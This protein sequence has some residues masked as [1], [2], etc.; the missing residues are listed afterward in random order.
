MIRLQ[1]RVFAPPEGVDPELTAVPLRA[2]RRHVFVQFNEIPSLQERR[3]IESDQLRILDPLPERAFFASVPNKLDVFKKLAS[4]SVRWIGAIHD[5]D[6]ILPELLKNGPPKY[7]ARGSGTSAYIVEFFADVD[8]AAQRRVLVQHHADQG[9]GRLIPINGWNIVMADAEL[10]PL[11]HED[12]VKWIVPAPEPPTVDND[13]VRS[14]TGVNS[15]P[16][17]SAPYNLSGSGVTIG[18]W[19]PARAFFPHPDLSGHAVAASTAVG[20]SERPTMHAENV[21]VNGAFDIGENI[22]SDM[23]DS[24]TVT[25]GDLRGSAVGAFAIG[26]VVAGADA[27]V[28]TALINFVGNTRSFDANFNGGYDPGEPFYLDANANH[29]VDVGETRLTA[30]GAFVAGSIVAVG[31]ADIGRVITRPTGS[32]IDSHPTHVACTAVGTGLQSVASGGS[33]NQWKGVAPS[34]SLRG[35][36]ASGLNAGYVDAATNAVAI[37]TNSWGSTHCFQTS[38]DNCYD[39]TSEFYDSVISGRQSSGVAS[40]LARRISIFG[41]AGNAGYPERHNESVAVN[42][43]FDNGEAVYTDFD[44]SGTV[45]LGDRRITASGAFAAG[46]FVAAGNADIGAALANFNGNERHPNSGGFIAGGAVYRDLDNSGTVTVGDLRITGAGAFAAGST[47]AVGNADIGTGLRMFAMWGTVRVPNSAKGTVEVANIASDNNV[48]DVASSRGPTSDGRLKPDISGPGI[49]FSG[50]LG[51]TSC[52]PPNSYFVDVGTS[53]AT[54]AVAGAGALVSEWYATA[55]VAAGPTPDALRALLVHSA[56]DK[57]AI[58]AVPGVFTGPDFQYGYG[59]AR[60]KEAVD[61]I[62]HHRQQSLAA[63]GSNDTTITIGTV[64][65]L[66]VT[67]AW[68]DPPHTGNAAPSAAIGLLQNDLDLLLIAPDGTQY[69]PWQLDPNN[70]ATPAVLTSTP[71]AMPIPAAAIDHRN[72]IEQVVVPSAMPGTWTIRVTASTLNIPPQNYTIVSEFLSPQSSP[73]SATP[74]VDAFMRDNAADTGTVPSTGTM[75]QSPDI[76]NRNAADGMT[77]HQNPIHGIA[78]PVAN[79]IYANVRNLSATDTLKAGRVDVWIAAAAVG[80]SWPM[81]FTY[82]GSIPV[83]NVAASAVQQAG[84]L[85]WFPP[86][87]SPSDHFCMYARLQG[88]QDPITFAETA[89]I[90]TNARNSNNII[91]KNVNIVAMSANSVAFQMRNVQAKAQDVD[92]VLRVPPEFLQAGGEIHAGL[93]REMERRWQRA[94][95]SEGMEVKE[96]QAP[97]RDP[98]IDRK[99]NDDLGPPSRVD[100]RVREAR[101][102]IRGIPMAPREVAPVRLAF[103][104]KNPIAGSEYKVEVV[105]MIDGQEIGGIAYLLRPGEHH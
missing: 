28:G 65:P 84:P 98:R 99:T 13:G 66:K 93:S 11:A 40:G 48:P 100:F 104:M 33:P 69:T 50:D 103:S 62:A 96:L 60:A 23:D 64:M 59:R 92:L 55:C 54:P 72:T 26:S 25:A 4:Q 43:Q 86:D 56:E 63:I 49:Q 27:D 38:P 90:D 24:S 46:T 6:K 3:R 79:F 15:N 53:M 36:L 29:I 95:K 31:D 58:P 35:Y 52:R 77:G 88:P 85:Q 32:G 75:W 82:V 7:A 10:K 101:A 71:A 74:A 5:T 41:S 80:L 47:V 14:A 94:R 89:N 42:N 70:P 67:L 61:L 17:T 12:A 87:P 9:S 8:A 34:A 45:S 39:V 68:D 57:T 21:T 91:W 105:E 22:Y 97:E 83:A 20:P 78:M 102:A 2:A 19:E 81:D 16:A 51:V 30:A 44:N 1:A 37:S 18:Q 73:C 76:W